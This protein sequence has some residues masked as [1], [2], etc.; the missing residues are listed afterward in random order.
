VSASERGLWWL[1]AARVY[2]GL[3]WLNYGTSKFEP[4]WARTEFLSAV[5]V[6]IADTSGPVREFLVNVVVPNQ[7]LFAQTIAVGETLVG[8]SLLFG[9]LTRAG[10]LGGMFLSLNYYFATGRYLHRFGIESLELLLFVVCVLLLV[11]P[12]A[13]VLSVDALIPR[14]RSGKSAA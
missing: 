14:G 12:S 5:R 9:L 2:V 10:A 7:S 6:C 8:I 13:R 11:L 4:Q 1:A 3:L